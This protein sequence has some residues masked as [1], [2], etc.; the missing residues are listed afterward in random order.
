MAAWLHGCMAAWLHGCMAAWLHGNE[1][2]PK[3]SLRASL[4]GGRAWPHRAT[5]PRMD[6]SGDPAMLRRV[7]RQPT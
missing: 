5:Q 6:Q 4:K 1:H 3:P 2:D 7:Q